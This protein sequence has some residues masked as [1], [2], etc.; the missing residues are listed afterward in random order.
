MST[1]TLSGI[2][3]IAAGVLNKIMKKSK[4]ELS[5]RLRMAPITRRLEHLISVSPLK[6]ENFLIIS[7]S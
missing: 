6:S 2:K 1:K 7:T 3:N 5:I 4:I